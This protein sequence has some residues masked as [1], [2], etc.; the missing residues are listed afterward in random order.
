[1][2]L[3]DGRLI[4]DDPSSLRILLSLLLLHIRS[5]P[6]LG[7]RTITGGTEPRYLH[8]LGVAAFEGRSTCRA[9][10]TRTLLW[11]SYYT[12]RLQDTTDFRRARV[13]RVLLEYW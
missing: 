8:V 10:E 11:S 5:H 3:W 1:M 4:L 9:E 13:V 12:L 6:F 7:C 2:L